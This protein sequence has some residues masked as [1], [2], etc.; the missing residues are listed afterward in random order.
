MSLVG[1]RPVET[2]DF[3]DVVARQ[4]DRVAASATRYFDAHARGRS[5]GDAARGLVG[6]VLVLYTLSM[7][8]LEGVASRGRGAVGP[9][10][11]E[12]LRGNMEELRRALNGVPPQE[13]AAMALAALQELI[14]ALDAAD[15]LVR[16]AWEIPRA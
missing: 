2:M 15:L 8:V 11:I 3:L 4:L 6:S 7:P 13:A 1:G 14:R 9:R 16:K 5:L 10:T 12:A